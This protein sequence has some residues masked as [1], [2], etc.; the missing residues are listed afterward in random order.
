MSSPSP[1]PERF[2]L[3]LLLLL[4]GCGTRAVV[5]GRVTYDGKAVEKGF[6]TFFPADGNG[7]TSGAEILQGEYRVDGISPGK[8]RVLVRAAPRPVVLPATREEP[9]RVQL[10][11]ADLPIP[12]DAGGNNQVVDIGPGRQTL[13]IGLKRLK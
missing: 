10:A 8:K 13:D 1:R 2:L 11:P 5:S 4:P 9:Q 12:A 3:L 7:N 6:I